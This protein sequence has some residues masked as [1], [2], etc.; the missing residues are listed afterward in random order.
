[1]VRRKID[2]TGNDI[3][4]FERRPLVVEPQRKRDKELDSA[5]ALFI[6]FVI[7]LAYLLGFVLITIYRMFV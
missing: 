5:R 1:M 7:S 4:E 6:G 2:L 3:P